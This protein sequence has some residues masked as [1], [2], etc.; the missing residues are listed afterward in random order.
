MKKRTPIFR[1]E[2]GWGASLIRKDQSAFLELKRD[3]RHDDEPYIRRIIPLY[4]DP[5]DFKIFQFECG[6]FVFF[7]TRK[8]KYGWNFNFAHIELDLSSLSHKVY[9]ITDV[10]FGENDL[11]EITEYKKG[12][13]IFRR[14]HYE[15]MVYL[16]SVGDF[17]DVFI[18][19][20]LGLD[21]KEGFV[22]VSLDT[23]SASSEII[24][25]VCGIVCFELPLKDVLQLKEEL[26]TSLTVV[27]PLVSGIHTHVGLKQ[28]KKYVKDEKQRIETGNSWVMGKGQNADG[29]GLRNDIYQNYLASWKEKLLKINNLIELKPELKP[30]SGLNC[31]GEWQIVSIISSR[32]ILEHSSTGEIII[33]EFG[34]GHPDSLR[35]LKN[36]NAFIG[37]SQYETENGKKFQLRRFQLLPDREKGRVLFSDFYD[38]SNNSEDSYNKC[39]ASDDILMLA[40]YRYSIKNN[41]F[42][43]ARKID[44]MSYDVIE[45]IYVV[46]K[47]Q[48]IKDIGHAIQVDV[49]IRKYNET[50]AVIALRAIGP[51]DRVYYEKAFDGYRGEIVQ[52]T[53]DS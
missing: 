29:I 40:G 39:Q 32:V 42:L 18:F 33:L 30:F 25:K 48:R 52:I 51:F 2:K 35:W 44:R 15:P 28:L 7:Y 11:T 36:A 43:D 24:V 13:F 41:A 3:Y 8:H 5:K 21:S 10:A 38:L 16:E 45:R 17:L 34:Q 20:V 27:L 46:E 23:N 14:K 9:K 53:K 37:F 47:K 6:S 12:I 1:G 19:K 22:S 31:I 26:T 50:T 4:G 49:V